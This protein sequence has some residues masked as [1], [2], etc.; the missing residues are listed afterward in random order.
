MINSMIKICTYCGAL[1]IELSIVLVFFVV[2]EPDYC[3]DIIS[4]VMSDVDG[5]CH[6][7][8]HWLV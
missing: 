5:I 8:E 7:N 1:F 2:A 4:V 3:A 6:V